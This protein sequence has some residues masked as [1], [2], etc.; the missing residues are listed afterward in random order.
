MRQQNK[1]KDKLKNKVVIIGVVVVSFY[2]IENLEDDIEYK[3]YYTADLGVLINNLVNIYGFVQILAYRQY[4]K[5]YLG[6][7][8]ELVLQ[9]LISGMMILQ[10]K[11]KEPINLKQLYDL[12]REYHKEEKHKGR[13]FLFCSVRKFGYHLQEPLCFDN[14]IIKKKDV[15]KINNNVSLSF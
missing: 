13:L 12:M 11:I 7:T 3:I 9:K 5:Y 10:D 15:I 14:K 6:W 4:I 2:K 1:I 8:T